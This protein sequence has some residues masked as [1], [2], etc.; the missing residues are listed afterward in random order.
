MKIDI[1]VSELQ[2]IIETIEHSVIEYGEDQI[3]TDII[4]KLKS[5][6]EKQ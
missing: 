2:Y 6:L 1:D 5:C 4:N 3:D